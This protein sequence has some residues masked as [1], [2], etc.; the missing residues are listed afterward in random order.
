MYHTRRRG[1]TLIELLVV[2]AIIAILS[3]ILFPVFAK[4]RE[5]AR[6][7][8]CSSNQKQLAT[9]I[10]LYVQEHDDQLPDSD[11]WASQV[12]VTAKVLD[13]V[14]APG[15]AVLTRP[16]YALN[17]MLQG[18][19]LGEVAVDPT[20]VWL[21]GDGAGGVTV[22][23]EL[24]LRH[25][26]KAIV[27][28][29]D[30][31][32][33]LGLQ[34]AFD[35]YGESKI[36]HQVLPVAGGDGAI[37]IF[38]T[39][40]AIFPAGSPADLAGKVLATYGNKLMLQN[41]PGVGCNAGGWRYQD[42]I[43][44]SITGVWS[45]PQLPPAGASNF[46]AG[47]TIAN[48]PSVFF[49]DTPLLAIS[50]GG[51]KVAICI[52]INFSEYYLLVLPTARLLESTPA[53][54]Q[55]SSVWKSAPL[56]GVTS[57]AWA[58]DNLLAINRGDWTNSY[59]EMLTPGSSVTHS[60]MMVPGSSGDIAFDG[61]QNLITGIGYLTGRTGEL[62]MVPYRV[63]Q[64][65]LAGTRA[66]V[67]FDNEALLLAR[68]AGSASSLG[69]DGEGNLHVSGTDMG[70]GAYGT[71]YLLRNDVLAR[72]LAGGAPAKMDN[73]RECRLF[74]PDPAKDDYAMV[75]LTNPVNDELL[76]IWIPNE[77]YPGEYFL[78]DTVPIMT[79]YSS[80]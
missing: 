38:G 9:A 50:P 64:Q 72:V 28:Y 49:L 8:A 36:N 76:I 4:A 35:K 2:I 59:I 62:R 15:K 58:S 42:I 3:A 68:G 29:L 78:S 17:V 51:G 21:T 79:S 48:D 54:L 26:G 66:P 55:D 30:G 19:R 16:E 39:D 71:V 22:A 56:F 24:Q 32:V 12:G 46:T 80:F 34:T 27:S 7:T 69:V 44:N 33:T 65:V 10:L 45:F 61:N 37:S 41:N 13:C 18:K 25:S 67:N 75:V 57:I 14:D 23:S 31:H 40:Y 11:Y 74:S 73:P 52:G 77:A 43:H 1:F 47:A 60:I 70:V 5:K 53:L 20:R 63:W 6:Q